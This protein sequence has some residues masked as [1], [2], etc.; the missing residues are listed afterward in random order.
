M[1]RRGATLLEAVVSITILSLAMISLMGIIAQ[2]V[3][4]EARA[5]ARLRAVHLA[6]E[7]L[8]VVR[9][10]GPEELRPRV[11]ETA[12]GGFPPPFDSY[13]WRVWIG[14]VEEVPALLAVDVLVEWDGGRMP[15]STVLYRPALRSLALE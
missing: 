5:R 14:R 6:A 1:T 11:D 15:L 3:D 9:A 13:V 8:E 10:L 2:Y 7:R 4:G 12:T